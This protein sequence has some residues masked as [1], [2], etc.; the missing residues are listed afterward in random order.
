MNTKKYLQTGTYAFYGYSYS[1]LPSE[2]I[3]NSKNIIKLF[4]KKNNQINKYKD[5]IDWSYYGGSSDTPWDTF[6]YFFAD[7]EAVKIL[8]IGFPTKSKYIYI[9][10]KYPKYYLFIIIGLIRRLIHGSIKIE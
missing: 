5:K 6:D 4:Y 2:I 3:N 9:S 10:L 1:K 7:Q 8:C